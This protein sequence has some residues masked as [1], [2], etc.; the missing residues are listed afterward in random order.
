[1]SNIYLIC[2]VRNC[3]DEVK[4]EIAKYVVDLEADGNKVHFPSRDVKQDQ[5]GM[6]ICETLGSVMYDCDEVHI[7][8]DPDSKGSYFDLGMAFMLHI[9]RGMKF[10]MANEIEET[11]HKS[12]GNVIRKLSQ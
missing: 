3:S 2:P 7:W 8:W 6:R 9:H 12:Y 4:E 10:V 1:M 5:S 11:S